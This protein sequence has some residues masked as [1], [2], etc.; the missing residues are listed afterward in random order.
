MSSG[1]GCGPKMLVR[2]YGKCVALENFNKINAAAAR[3]RP[4]HHL[5]EYYRQMFEYK[6][7][8][9]AYITPSMEVVFRMIKSLGQKNTDI[10]VLRKDM[11]WIEGAGN[12]G[13]R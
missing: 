11:K 9:G 12:K 4:K 2:A 5:P 1:L 3:A 13:S 7:E 6:D 10:E 8:H